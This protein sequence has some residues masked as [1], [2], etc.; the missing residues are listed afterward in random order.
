MSKNLKIF[1]AVAIIV[2]VA[3]GWV[4]GYYNSFVQANIAIDQQWS[5]VENQ[6]Q[7]RFDLIPNLVASVQGIFDQERA[8][9]DN[10]ADARSRYAGAVSVDNKAAAATQVESALA[11]LL[12]VVEAYPELRS[13]ENVQQFQAQ[14]EGT[15]NRV[16]VERG[17]FNDAV[18]KYNIRIAKFPG[19]VFAGIFGFASR[20][21]FEAVEGTEVAPTVEFNN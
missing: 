10:L 8:V 18:G 12:V 4:V 5:Q 1:I 19:N 6:Y 15:E 14:L 11:R 16:S 7:R 9:F 21:F 2:V 3:V 17:R 13:T 20:A